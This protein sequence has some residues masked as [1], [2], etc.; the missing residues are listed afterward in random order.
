MF[1]INYNDPYLNNDGSVVPIGD[2]IGGG[3]GG[4]GGSATILHGNTPPDASLGKEGDIY[5]Y[6]PSDARQEFTLT[7]S[8]ALRG[9]TEQSYSGAQEI[10]LFFTDGT[11]SKNI[12]QFPGFYCESNGGTISYAFDGNTA[13]SYWEKSGLPAIVQFGAII[14]IGWRIE[15]LVVWQRNNETYPDV[16]KTFDLKY[17]NTPIL[18]ESDL[19]QSDWEGI[20]KGTTFDDFTNDTVDSVVRTYYKTKI[21][22]VLQWIS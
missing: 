5:L 21:G 7:I 17:K 6:M 8:K 1:P 2:V 4:G 22:D 18:S 9:D 15:K 20:G 19:T 3:G 10:Q 11:T 14:P 12:I 13:G 16:W